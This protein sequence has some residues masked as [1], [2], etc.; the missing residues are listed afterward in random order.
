[1]EI[2]NTILSFCYSRKVLGYKRKIE[3]FYNL[4]TSIGSIRLKAINT[5]TLE[6]WSKELGISLEEAR[7]FV[8]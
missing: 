2:S 1:M 8:L 3:H 7:K 5:N 6:G 4:Y